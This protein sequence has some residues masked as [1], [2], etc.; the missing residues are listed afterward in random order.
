MLAEVVGDLPAE[1]GRGRL[2]DDAGPAF[3]AARHLEQLR[4][5]ADLANRFGRDLGDVTTCQRLQFHWLSSRTCPDIFESLD[6]CG[7][8]AAQACG[9]VWR[10]VVDLSAPGVIADEHFDSTPQSRPHRGAL[11][12]QPPLL[13]PAPEVKVSGLDRAPTT[14]PSTRSTTSPSSAGWSIPSSASA[15]T[16][17]SAAAWGASARIGRRLDVFVTAPRR[18]PGRRRRSPPSTATTATASSG[19]APRSKF[20]ARRVGRRRFRAALEERLGYRAHRGPATG[21]RT[22]PMRDHV[23]ITPQARPAATPSAARPSAAARPGTADRRSPTSPTARVRPRPLDQPPEPDRRL[24]IPARRRRARRRPTWPASA[25]RSHA[26]PFRRQTI[27]CTGIEFCRL[28]SPRRRRSRRD[29]RPPRGPPRRP[30]PGRPDQRQRLPERL[31]PVPDRRH[32][33]AGRPGQEG[34]REG[35]RVPAPHRRPAGTAPARAPHRQADPGRRERA[36]CSSGSSSPTAT[37]RC[38]TSRSAWGFDRQPEGPLA[39]SWGAPVIA[40]RDLGEV[41]LR[42]GELAASSLRLAGLAGRAARR[43]RPSPDRGVRGPDPLPLPPHPGRPRAPLGA[44]PGGGRSPRPD[45]RPGA[46]RPPRGA[47]DDPGH[48]DRALRRSGELVLRLPS[49]L[50]RR[51]G[52]A[53]VRLLDG[54]RAR[55][56]GEGR[57]IVE[58]VP[59]GGARPLPLPGRGRRPPPG[60]ARRRPRGGRRRRR[61][62]VDV[63]DRRRSTRGGRRHDPDF[64]SESALRRP[65]PRRLHVPG[66]RG[67][68]RTGPSRASSSSGARPSAPRDPAG[69]RR[70]RLL[71][72]R[73]A[74][75][76]HLVRPHRLLGYPNVRVYDGS[77]ADGNAI[78]CRSPSSP[79]EDARFS[80]ARPPRPKGS[81]PPF[82]GSGSEP[83]SRGRREATADYHRQPGPG[84]GRSE[85]RFR[86]HAHRRLGRG[87]P[88]GRRLGRGRSRLRNGCRQELR[89]LPRSIKWA[90]RG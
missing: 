65:H 59:G 60:A 56:I 23:G 39:R 37:R 43:P 85:G 46:G 24:D 55:W 42:P 75:G 66:P 47:R 74:G 48:D 79:D 45:R 20:L 77:W 31:R 57:E 50:L 81:R 3:P 54:G 10:N 35:A 12:R 62:F 33:P 52:H 84:P 64:P 63:R 78:T 80:P 17:G 40:S 68:R 49:W 73:R 82:L 90:R 76:P 83:P 26:P 25:F 69:G 61:H 27:S 2:P 36:S 86:A 4:L 14:A 32:R 67:P 6:A 30:R 44:R 29:H 13:E 89:S 53:D 5:C 8:T 34:R 22:T 38:R 88:P 58:A 28:A 71:P 41:I 9:D 7:M 11:H 21:G 16:S 87:F 15:T 19:R 70:D 1:P 18:S 51:A 72:D